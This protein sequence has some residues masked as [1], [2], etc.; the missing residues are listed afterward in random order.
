MKFARRTLLLPAAILMFSA[1]FTAEEAG[2]ASE[3]VQQ[4]TGVTYEAITS[5]SDVED[6]REVLQVATAIHCAA[7]LGEW[8][9]RALIECDNVA[10]F[11]DGVFCQAEAKQHFDKIRLLCLQLVDGNPGGDTPPPPPADEPPPPPPPSWEPCGGSCQ[12]PFYCD[13]STDNCIC[14][15]SCDAVCGGTD[16]CGN[17]CPY[18]PEQCG[19]GGG[20]GG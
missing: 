14:V 7:R 10:G 8:Y 11:S 6:V 13:T 12:A 1:A 18:Y 4:I 16:A 17:E 9:E 5:I 15:S 3:R 20:S 19:G 2:C